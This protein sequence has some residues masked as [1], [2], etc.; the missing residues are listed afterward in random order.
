MF[1]MYMHSIR[2]QTMGLIL[3]R[4]K[5]LNFPQKCCWLSQLWLC[6]FFPFVSAEMKNEIEC[7]IF[8]INVSFFPQKKKNIMQIL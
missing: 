7:D 5:M 3:G 8:C 1:W 6:F 4:S 2:M